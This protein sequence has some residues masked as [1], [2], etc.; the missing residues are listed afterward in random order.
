MVQQ[1]KK[2][3]RAIFS[4]SPMLEEGQKRLGYVGD[5]EGFAQRKTPLFFFKCVHT[6]YGKS[7]I[8][9]QQQPGFQKP[10]EMGGR[11]KSCLQLPLGP[12][13]SPLPSVCCFL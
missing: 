8:H 10:Q 6:S 12:H 1:G 9:P 7:L 11:E 2:G 3:E 4:L 5:G 13:A